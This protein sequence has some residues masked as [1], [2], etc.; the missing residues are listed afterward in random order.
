MKRSIWYLGWETPCFQSYGLYIFGLFNT[1]SMFWYFNIE[2]FIE[3]S[4]GDF[5]SFMSKRADPSKWPEV[6]DI[7]WFSFLL[8]LFHIHT[9]KGHSVSPSTTSFFFNS[10]YFGWPRCSKELLMFVLLVFRALIEVVWLTENDLVGKTLYPSRD[11]EHSKYFKTHEIMSMF[12]NHF[13]SSN[14]QKHS[15]TFHDFKPLVNQICPLRS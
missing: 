5:S 13:T 8:H 9:V 14:R 6:S 11:L 10:F 15:R 4:Y 1:W 3:W 2:A 12:F 7:E